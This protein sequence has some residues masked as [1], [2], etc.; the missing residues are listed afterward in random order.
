MK[1]TAGNHGIVSS[2]NHNFG[3]FYS[4]GGATADAKKYY[5][6]TSINNDSIIGRDCIFHHLLVTVYPLQ[7]QLFLTVYSVV[8]M[9]PITNDNIVLPDQQPV[10]S[11]ISPQDIEHWYRSSNLT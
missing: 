7:L 1:K 11:I 8:P 2:G 9:L 6:S 5:A 3:A 10:M 4:D